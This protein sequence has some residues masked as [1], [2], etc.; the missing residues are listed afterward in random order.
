MPKFGSNSKASRLCVGEN[1]QYWWAGC[2]TPRGS[3]STFRCHTCIHTNS[4]EGNKKRTSMF[5]I[6]IRVGGV[7]LKAAS[8]LTNLMQLVMRIMD[9]EWNLLLIIKLEFLFGRSCLSWRCETKNE[10]SWSIADFWFV[11]WCVM[12][13][14]FKNT[15][16]SW[17]F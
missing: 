16:V 4:N 14:K 3:W 6:F 8:N 11:L 5:H 17:T 7:T 13:A 10:S 9:Q 12:V 2:T 15:E 1:L